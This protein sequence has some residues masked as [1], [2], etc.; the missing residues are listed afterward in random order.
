MP[1]LDAKDYLLIA[2]AAF[3]L[4]YVVRL[5]AA[6]RV[7][8]TMAPGSGVAPTLWG[9]VTGFVTN[10]FDTLGIGSFAT[11]TAI[12]RWRK[13]VRDEQIPGT[14]N[15]GHTL[16]TVVQA[17]I[18]TK[19]VEV[20]A[21]TLILLIGAA[22]AGSYL[23]AGVVSAWP[24]RKIQLGMGFALAAAALLIVLAQVGIA[25][26]GGTELAL[27]GPKLAIAVAANMF[28]GALMTLGIGLYAPCMILIYLLGMAPLAAFPIM[29]GSCAFLMPVASARFMKA[30]A[31]DLKAS[32]GLLFGGIPAVVIAATIVKSLNLYWMRWVVVV[33]VLYTAFGMLRAGFRAHEGETIPG[34]GGVGAAAE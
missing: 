29:M 9:I 31:F 28:L 13:M 12:F 16:A 32:L 25:P 10:F 24:R 26:S 1:N 4:F 2:L 14:L 7:E 34:A 18:F 17:F 21:L 30:R 20:D 5:L 3:A 15:V 27:T 19:L 8:R 6:I 22:I 33:V 11:T 23:G